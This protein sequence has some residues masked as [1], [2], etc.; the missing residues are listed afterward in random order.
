MYTA[1]RC[2]IPFNTLCCIANI[3]LMIPGTR[4]Q[5]LRQQRKQASAL[6]LAECNS[7]WT[8][9]TD[10]IMTVLGASRRVATIQNMRTVIDVFLRL[11]ACRRSRNGNK[12]MPTW[13]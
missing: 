8:N 3:D 4:E 7:R 12:A 5:Y 6:Y 11:Q 13:H 10:A 2:G 9:Y 1:A